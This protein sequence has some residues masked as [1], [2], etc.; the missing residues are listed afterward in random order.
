MR[1]SKHSTVLDLGNLQAPEGSALWCTA[2][3]IEVWQVLAELKRVRE[4]AAVV[5]G[6]LRRDE[7]FRRLKDRKGREFESWQ[8]FCGEPFPYGLGMTP[9]DLDDLLGALAPPA[10]LNSTCADALRLPTHG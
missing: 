4:Q 5:V 6:A 7:N 9:E 10:L 1:H 8:A 2:I 3:R